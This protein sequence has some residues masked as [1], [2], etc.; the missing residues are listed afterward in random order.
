ML[1]EPR[2]PRNCFFFIADRRRRLSSQRRTRARCADM[3]ATSMHVGDLRPLTRN[4][5]VYF[6]HV[7][8]ERTCVYVYIYTLVFEP[9]RP[10]LLAGISLRPSSNTSGTCPH[11]LTATPPRA[12][13]TF[14]PARWQTKS[15]QR[16]VVRP[17]HIYI[18]IST[19]TYVDAAVDA[20][21]HGIYAPGL[22]VS[23][24][25]SLSADVLVPA[26]LAFFRTFLLS[27]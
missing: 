25:N 17:E 8:D 16:H 18:H 22:L 7:F 20:P 10:V 19:H 6:I 5:K 1:T 2:F 13:L 11:M 14:C 15:F 27:S 26:A 24:A 21:A 3:L 9:G 4:G 23:T 12:M